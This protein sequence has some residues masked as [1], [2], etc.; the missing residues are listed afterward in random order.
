MAAN[1][2]ARQTA[3]KYPKTSGC[4]LKHTPPRAH[5]EM[6]LELVSGA[7][8]WCKLMSGGRPVDL[9]GPGVDFRAKTPEN[10][11][12]NF[13]VYTLFTPFFRTGPFVPTTI[14]SGRVVGTSCPSRTCTSRCGVWDVSPAMA[15]ELV[16]GADFWCKSMSG[17]R[18]VDL[19]GSRGRSPG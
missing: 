18:P 19:G 3:F 1:E 5:S 16:S 10:R 8:F 15:L 7:D 4:V 12:E 14:F 2:K 9:G 11:P 13:D 6:A 17:G